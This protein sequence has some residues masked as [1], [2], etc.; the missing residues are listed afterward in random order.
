MSTGTWIAQSST[1]S[2]LMFGIDDVLDR[3]Q[4]GRDE[5]PPRRGSAERRRP[6]RRVHSRG[7]GKRRSNRDAHEDGWSS[8]DASDCDGVP[9]GASLAADVVKQQQWIDPSMGDEVR[10]TDRAHDRLEQ[11]FLR[12]APRTN[13]YIDDVAITDFKESFWR[14]LKC[15]GWQMGARVLYM[16][17][18]DALAKSYGRGC[19]MMA[20]RNP[21][22]GL[23]FVQ[24]REHQENKIDT[25]TGIFTLEKSFQMIRV[26]PYQVIER[27]RLL[28]SFSVKDNKSIDTWT[29]EMIDE[30]AVDPVD[31]LPDIDVLPRPSSDE[32]LPD[33]DAASTGGSNANTPSPP[34]TPE[35]SIS[36][37]AYDMGD[38]IR[39]FPE[40]EWELD[41]D[42]IPDFGECTRD[43]RSFSSVGPDPFASLDG[44]LR[45]RSKSSASLTSLGSMTS[46]ISTTSMRSLGGHRPKVKK[47]STFRQLFRS[48]LDI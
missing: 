26:E 8:A 10:W 36:Q 18:G 23:L 7:S 13:L 47:S 35:R 34:P 48:F 3:G 11:D 16:C 4:P 17:T 14:I 31:K 38:L 21:D 20:K 40:N 6:R 2:D 5:T 39:L 25:E 45:E 9:D 28:K 15:F 19:T 43:S 22:P 12:D 37:S 46:V 42:L 29:R 32:N 44:D 24:C 1:K 27:W 41:M 33:S 30:P